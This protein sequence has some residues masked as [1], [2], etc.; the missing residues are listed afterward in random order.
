MIKPPAL[1]LGAIIGIVSPS[2][3]IDTTDLN[4]AKTIF[5]NKGYN[6]VLGESVFLKDGTYAGK[7]EQRANDINGMFANKKIDAIICARGGYGANRVLSLL[8][9]DLIRKNPKIFIGYS[10]ITAFLTS[11]TQQTGLITFHGPMLSSFKNG[12]V[13]YNLTLMEKV[14]SGVNNIV[15]EPPSE[16]PI[17][18]LKSGKAE[19]QLWGGNMCLLINRLG[20][21]DQLNTDGVILFLE[22]IGEYLYAF[23]RMLFHMKEAKMFHNIKGLIVGEFKNMKDQDTPFGKSTDEIIMDVCDDL[24]IPIVSNFPCGHGIF[25]ATLPISAPVQ[26]NTE[27]NSAPL[28]ILESPVK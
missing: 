16:L 7:P 11:I 27:S 18:I 28:K 19:G 17:R 4:T 14:T 23:D 5:E 6:L 12:N 8:D 21:S 25:Q 13:E 22:D 2:S 20:T 24:D 26:L 3:W 15:I 10:D 9:Y 1:K